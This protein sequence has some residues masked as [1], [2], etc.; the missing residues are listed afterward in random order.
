M[1][2][3]QA[4]RWGLVSLLL[5]A[6]TLFPKASSGAVATR[7]PHAPVRTWSSSSVIGEAIGEAGGIQLSLRLATGPYF[8]S[9]LLPVRI[10]LRNHTSHALSLD[11]D[12]TPD[13]ANPALGVSTSGGTF[14][15]YALPFR[16]LGTSRG[17]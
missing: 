11:G 3:W 13:F 9:E 4:L 16:V 5:T 8:L 1:Q 7:L 12:P 2:S 15:T 17:A 6:G 10:A 14:P